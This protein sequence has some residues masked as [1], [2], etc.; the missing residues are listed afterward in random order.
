M[1]FWAYIKGICR[2]LRAAHG[3][4]LRLLHLPLDFVQVLFCLLHL[5][6]LIRQKLVLPFSEDFKIN[7]ITN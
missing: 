3:L 2:R 6:F 7:I 4:H 5:L 1:K